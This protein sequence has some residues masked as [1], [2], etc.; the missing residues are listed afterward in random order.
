MP[1]THAATRREF[2]QSAACTA[3]AATQTI[4]AVHAADSNA[5]PIVDTHQHLWDLQRFDLPW[6]AEAPE[7]LRQSYRY[8]DYRVAVRDL[9]VRQCVYMEVDVAPQQQRDEAE[10]VIEL[11]QDPKNPTVGGVISGTLRV[12]FV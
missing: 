10:F 8:G 2:L 7:I 11:C 1:I 4:G 3:L 6:L 12:R 5:L 9:N